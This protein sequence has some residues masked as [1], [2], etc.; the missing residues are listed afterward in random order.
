MSI[1]PFL[2]VSCAYQRDHT[3]SPQNHPTGLLL[4]TIPAAP[5]AI[6]P[7]SQAVKADDL[8]FASGCI[9]LD[10]A[11]GQI[12]EGGIEPQTEQALKNL[13]AV[14]EA[15]ES[16]LGKVVKTTVRLSCRMALEIATGHNIF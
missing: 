3:R 13:K 2:P 8:L 15:G 7:Y 1:G 16:T 9:P 6:G 14:V 11:T 12:V 10:P 5:A 4:Y